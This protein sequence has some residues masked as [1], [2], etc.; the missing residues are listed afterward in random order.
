MSGQCWVWVLHKILRK[1]QDVLGGETHC[2]A[3]LKYKL[4]QCYNEIKK[5]YNLNFINS[6]NSHYFHCDMLPPEQKHLTK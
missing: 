6:Q 3:S 5:I 4:R 2:L 1:L